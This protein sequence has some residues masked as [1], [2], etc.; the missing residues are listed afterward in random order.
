[1]PHRI[2]GFVKQLRRTPSKAE[3]ETRAPL[4]PEEARKA[5]EQRKA[6]LKAKLRQDAGWLRHRKPWRNR[7]SRTA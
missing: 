3:A 7:K 1:M 2:I 4:S 6:E 5:A